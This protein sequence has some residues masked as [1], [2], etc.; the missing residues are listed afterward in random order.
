[1]ID[2]YRMLAAYNAWANRALYDATGNLPGEAWRKDLGAFFGSLHGTLNHLL[3]ADRVWLKRFT[4]AGDAPTS[5][6][7]ILFEDFTGLRQAR[8]AEDAR[9]AAFADSLT[10]E[11]V[12]ADITYSPL[13]NPGII[14]NPL[15]PEL[16]HII[17]HN[18]HHLGH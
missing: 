8:Q 11:A 13:S 14:T 7:A 1:M 5:L 15:G 9:L 12:A 10:E 17:N 16:T 2:H 6:D 4:G 18:T 3:T